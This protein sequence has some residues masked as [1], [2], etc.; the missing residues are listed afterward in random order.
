M[1]IASSDGI[2]NPPGTSA[3]AAE[4]AALL[5]SLIL[6]STNIGAAVDSVVMGEVVMG[7]VVMGEAVPGKA[8]LGR[9]GG[10]SPSV[11]AEAAIGRGS[12]KLLSITG[13]GAGGIGMPRWFVAGWACCAGGIEATSRG[14]AAKPGS[15]SPLDRPADAGA[16]NSADRLMDAPGSRDGIEASANEAGLPPR[17][18]G[19]ARVGAAIPRGLGMAMAEGSSR[20]A[21]RFVGVPSQR[22]AELPGKPPRDKIPPS[23]PTV[24]RGLRLELDAGSF[25]TE[26]AAGSFATEPD[27]GS[28]A[29]EPE[30]ESFA[31]E[32]LL[33]EVEVGTDAVAGVRADGAGNCVSGAPGDAATS[34]RTHLP[35]LQHPIM[36]P[37]SKAPAPAQSRRA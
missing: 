15:I 4:V 31:T 12:S 21:A 29:S 7:E 17:F 18:A 23:A 13:G 24:A 30:G 25:P 6:G 10:T 11:A 28:M 8:V 5:D 19:I 27:A 34:L 3:F 35:S 26:A 16:A 20:D 14:A 37:L 36:E 33:A 22:R 1:G 32:L 2:T 9:E